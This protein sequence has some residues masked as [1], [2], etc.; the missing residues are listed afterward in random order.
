MASATNYCH[1]RSGPSRLAGT[2][3]SNSDTATAVCVWGGASVRAGACA[4]VCVRPSVRVCVRDVVAIY[5]NNILP[6][7]IMIIIKNIIL[8]FIQIRHTGDLPSTGTR[9]VSIIH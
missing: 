8:Y 5:D 3:P 4:C 1:Q 6:R 2:D 7:L 9:L